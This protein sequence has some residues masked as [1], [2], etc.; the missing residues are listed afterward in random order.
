MILYNNIIKWIRSIWI[1]CS[2]HLDVKS[3]KVRLQ[4]GNV[5]L[6]LDKVQ[7]TNCSVNSVINWFITRTINISN[8]IYLT[9]RQHVQIVEW[10]VPQISTTTNWDCLIE[11][12]YNNKRLITISIRVVLKYRSNSCLENSNLRVDQLYW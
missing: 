3:V 12:S 9:V 2:R 7:N 1:L 5:G 11:I 8:S 4:N 6:V 10:M